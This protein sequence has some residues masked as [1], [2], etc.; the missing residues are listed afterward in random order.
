[1]RDRDRL[2]KDDIYT[3]MGGEFGAVIARSLSPM[4]VRTV[5]IQSIDVENNNAMTVVFE[6]DEPMP[7]PMTLLNIPEG[8]FRVTPTVGSLALVGTS[9]SDEN[10]PFFISYSQ[11]DKME[12]FRK[13]STVT[14]V[15]DPEDEAK[16][17]I[18]VTIGASRVYVNATEIR[19]EVSSKTPGEDEER[20]PVAVAYLNKDLIHANVKDDTNI[21]VTDKK[22]SATIGSDVALVATDKEL[23][24]KTGASTLKMDDSIIDF[25]GGG[26]DGLVKIN[27]ITDKLNDFVKKFNAHDHMI[28]PASFLISAMAGVPNPAPVAVLATTGISNPFV[29]SDY[30]NTKIVQG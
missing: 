6:D 4:R 21:D 7:V 24:V 28:P 3:R 27:E 13:N 1:M 5:T 12:M 15:T 23:N 8:M 30:E 18:E 9:N 29:K 17:S 25:N 19:A 10:A 14:V 11:V 20:D 22:I 16:D 26:L 2:N